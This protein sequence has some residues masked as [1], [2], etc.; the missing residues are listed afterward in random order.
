MINPNSFN[1]S[2]KTNVIS[3]KSVG[4]KPFV[5]GDNSFSMEETWKD[6]DGYNNAYQISN[7]GNVRSAHKSKKILKTDKDDPDRYVSVTLYLSVGKRRKEKIHRLIAKAFIPNPENKSQVNHINGNKKDNS[8]E[9]F[10]WCTPSENVIHSYKTGLQKITRGSES[11]NVKLSEEQVLSIRNEYAKGGIF[12]KDL[13][14]K[15]KVATSTI[16]AVIQR[17]NWKHI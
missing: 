10:E 13:A 7:L 17:H 6:I 16:C 3:P 14:K 12:M 4:I 2:P 5:V 11:V 9:I 8:L 15:Y 1:E